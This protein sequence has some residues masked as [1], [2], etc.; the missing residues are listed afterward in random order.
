MLFLISIFPV[1]FLQS[2]DEDCTDGVRLIV[3]VE[4]GTSVKVGAGVS[5]EVGVSDAGGADAVSAWLTAFSISA[6]VVSCALEVAS[7]CS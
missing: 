2:P 5:V 7:I 4:V 1:S 3:G 6:V